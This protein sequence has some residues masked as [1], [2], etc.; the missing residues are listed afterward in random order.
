[1]KNTEGLNNEVRQ[2]TCPADFLSSKVGSNIAVNGQAHKI[3]SILFGEE[4]LSPVYIET[5]RKTK[6][7]TDYYTFEV[8]NT[9]KGQ[10]LEIISYSCNS[11]SKEGRDYYTFELKNTNKGQELKIISYS[12]NSSLV[13]TENMRK[14]RLWLDL[15]ALMHHKSLT[16]NFE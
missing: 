13:S 2:V 7:G 14:M 8:K 1:M 11:S 9:N 15:D 12:C 3:E 5:S 10:K 4:I 6:E 16:W